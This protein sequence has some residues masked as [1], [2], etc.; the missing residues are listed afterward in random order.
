MR[1]LCAPPVQIGLTITSKNNKETEPEA[2][3]ALQDLYVDDL[4]TGATSEEKAFQIYESTKRVMKCGGF[5]LRKW[6]SNSKALS[7]RIGECETINESKP[8]DLLEKASVIEDD[9]TYVET[10][11]RP[12][13]VDESKTKILGLSWNTKEDEPFFE[14]SEITSYAK[15]LPQTKRSVQMFSTLLGFL[16]L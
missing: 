11:V 13:A 7:D 16:V 9:S 10:V 15:Q 12:Q 14:F 3:Q 4:P 8:E 5:N 2:V 1:S 6:K